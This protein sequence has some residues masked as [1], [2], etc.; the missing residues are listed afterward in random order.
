TAAVRA[1]AAVDPADALGREASP[2]LAA[3]GYD[4]VGIDVLVART[5]RPAS[6]VGAQLVQLQLQ[7]RVDALPG[8]LWQCRR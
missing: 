5:G 3:M 7:E 2:L 4:P 8:G 1:T 6:E